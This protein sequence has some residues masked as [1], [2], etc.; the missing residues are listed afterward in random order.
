M[1]NS[2]RS[3][4]RLRQFSVS[5]HCVV[6]SASLLKSGEFEQHDSL[7]LKQLPV[8]SRVT[9]DNSTV[10]FGGTIGAF[11]ALRCSCLREFATDTGG[12]HVAE[13]DPQ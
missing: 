11:I 1:E 6:H 13:T 3:Q 7:R 8:Y 10:I 9:R 2:F 5:E 12:M 4:L